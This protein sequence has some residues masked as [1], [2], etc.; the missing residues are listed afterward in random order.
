MKF[1]TSQRFNMKNPKCHCYGGFDCEVCNP[2]KYKTM[3]KPNKSANDWLKS[4]MDEH[5]PVGKPDDVPEGW[6]TIMEMCKIYQ[7]PMTTMNS[8]LMKLTNAGKIKRKQFWID[9]GRGIAKVF[10]YNKV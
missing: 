2:E 7:V 5:C 8:R 6:M 10:H 3:K 1:G 4:M 9:T